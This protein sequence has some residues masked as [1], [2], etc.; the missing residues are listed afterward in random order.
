MGRRFGF[1]FRNNYMFSE[2][3]IVPDPT[4]ETA[5]KGG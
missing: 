4:C 1:R 3:G 5:D 2:G